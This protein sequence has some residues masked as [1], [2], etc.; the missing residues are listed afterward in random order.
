MKNIELPRRVVVGDN[1]VNYISRVC[2][3]LD[4]AGNSLVISDEI[5][6]KVAGKKVAESLGSELVIIETK[7][8]DFKEILRCIKNKKINFISGV[9]GGKVIDTAKYTS[10]KS[11]IP[12]LSIPTSAAHDGITSPLVSLKKDKP[13][14]IKAR[15]PVAIIAD[16]NIIKKAPHRLLAAGCADAIS[17]YTAVLDWKLAHKEKGEYYGDYASSLSM[18]SAQIVMDNAKKI[19]DD[20]S[21]VV[22]ALI[23]SGVAIGIADSS[24]PCS[25]S[26][27]LFSHA[28][29]IIC[30]KPALHGEQCGVGTIMI[31]Y[32]HGD[33]NWKKIKEAL[34]IIGAPVT[35]EELGIE[36]EYIIKALTIAA[37]LRD[38]YTILRDGLSEKEAEG[39]AEATGVI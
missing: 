37:S 14:S 28:L 9:G 29:D 17:N 23:S 13:I 7:V 4:L 39:L 5:T 25:G 27:H 35:A 33:E 38:R 1:A 26:E 10:Y 19:S 36:N 2:R 15:S 24:R 34:K 20:V 6:Y 30:P 11:K 16:T 18:L 3:E 32:L 21:I 8:P 22:E 31:A 12:F